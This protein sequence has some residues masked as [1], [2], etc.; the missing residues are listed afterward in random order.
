VIR[1]VFDHV[2]TSELGFWAL[3]I[4]NSAGFAYV[5]SQPLR[6]DAQ[7]TNQPTN[8][9][10]KQINQEKCYVIDTKRIPPPPYPIQTLVKTSFNGKTTAHSQAAF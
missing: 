10:N 9:P 3:P 4:S 5:D 8:Q 2:H 6:L 1:I 7:V